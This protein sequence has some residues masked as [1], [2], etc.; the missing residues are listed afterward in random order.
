MSEKRSSCGSEIQDGGRRGCPACGAAVAAR[1]RGGG[2]SRWPW[3]A[4]L[5]LV[6]AAFGAAPAADKAPE[7]DS[8]NAE[9]KGLKTD[10]TPTPQVG[11][12]RKVVLAPGVEIEMVWCPAGTFMMGSPEDEAGRDDDETRHEVA[13]TKGFWIGK[14]EVTQRQWEAVMGEPPSWFKNA[15]PDAP[16]EEVS[17]D[18]CQKFIEKVNA[19]VP[20]GG[21]R[22]PTEAEWEYACRAGTATAFHYGN[23]LDSTLANFDGNYPYGNGRKGE[24]RRT[25]VRVG[26]FRPNAWGI[27]DMHGNVWEWCEDGYGDYPSGSVVDPRGPGSGAHR[28]CCGGSWNGSA[29]RC[30]SAY[31]LRVAPGSSLGILGLRLARTFDAP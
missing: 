3:A 9:T 21:F 10:A 26:S 1:Q 16:V 12:V 14:H 11:E 5:A 29:R 30:R 18:D 27:H 22:L 4:A 28:V 6:V 8:G 13:L 25:T 23:D 19:P 2:K 24:Y 15:G 31:R 20:G 7:I 17:W